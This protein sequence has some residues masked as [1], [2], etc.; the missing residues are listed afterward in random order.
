MLNYRLGGSAVLA[1]SPRSQEGGGV[2]GMTSGGRGAGWAA[3]QSPTGEATE[4]VGVATTTE[5]RG[6]G[7]G[8]SCGATRAKSMLC[9]EVRPG[10]VWSPFLSVTF[11]GRSSSPAR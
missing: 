3:G 6:W 11:S 2:W 9:G 8:A 10:L 4:S 7:W 1:A 5:T